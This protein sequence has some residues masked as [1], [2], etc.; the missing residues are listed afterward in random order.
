MPVER[1]GGSFAPPLSDELLARYKSLRDRLEPVYRDALSTLLACVE[2]WW[3][4][5]ESTGGGRPHPV[6]RGFIVDLD[7]EIK[8]KLWDSI[9]WGHELDALQSLLENL[10]SS[11]AAENERRLQAWRNAVFAVLKPSFVSPSLDL[12]KSGQDVKLLLLNDSERLRALGVLSAEQLDAISVALFGAATSLV[13]DAV[14]RHREWHAAAA[15]AIQSSDPP[16]ARPAL[17]DVSA[18]DAAFHLLWFVRELD[19]DREPLT[20]DKL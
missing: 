4:L 16:V 18:R 20:N 13:T 7:D 1:I 19:R 11:E 6:G 17:L 12:T 2:L 10:Q 3:E 14:A 8:Q 15:S 5:P 9:P